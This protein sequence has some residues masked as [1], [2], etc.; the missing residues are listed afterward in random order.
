MVLALH[1][2]RETDSVDPDLERRFLEKIEIGY[3]RLLTFEVPSEPGGFDWWGRAP[4]NLF[5]SAYG[6]MAF[7]DLAEV[8]TVDPALPPRIVTYLLSK[9]TED[10]SFRPDGIKTG[11]STDMAKGRA[12]LLTAYIAWGLARAGQPN[13][14]AIAWLE[15]HADEAEDP[16]GLAL[17][18]LALQASDKASKLAPRLLARLVARQAR[19]GLGVHWIPENETGVGGRGQSA[20]IETTALA[21]QALLGDARH[22]GLAQRAVERL[23]YWRDDRGRFGTTQSTIL[24][25]KALLAAEMASTPWSDT[26]CTVHDDTATLAVLPL[27]STST[28]P[29]HVDLGGRVPSEVRLANDARA[30]AVLS[31]TTWHPWT[32]TRAPAGRLT[33]EVAWPEETLDVEVPATAHVRV[34]NRASEEA[35]VVTLEIGV[36]PGCTVRAE[37]VR[38]EGAERVE[39][40]D[41]TIVIYL[42]SLAPGESLSFVVP[43][44]PRYAL[45]VKTAPSKAYEYYVPEEAV[46]VAPA[47]VWAGNLPEGATDGDS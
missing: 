18:A 35:S 33:L 29:E 27:S 28:E 5:L 38:G 43:F 19:D 30:Q 42:R 34:R 41:T 37:D 22:V 14:K 46:I 13:A 17:A 9:Q 21:I 32:T 24:A 12:Y 15:T 4:A 36:P 31:R 39:R 1:Y 2:M 40:G 10:G 45:R 8:T 47:T 6:L 25:L 11:W 44:T 20:A 3:K 7:L 23:A 16:Y 26:V